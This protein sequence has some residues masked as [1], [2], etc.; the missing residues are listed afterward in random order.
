ML[1]SSS[2][3]RENYL[4]ARLRDERTRLGDITMHEKPNI[5]ILRTLLEMNR[6]HPAIHGNLA[7]LEAYLKLARDHHGDVKAVYK[8]KDLSIHAPDDYR[9]S[10]FVGRS[11][12]AG[13]AT[14]LPKAVVNTIWKDTHVEVDLVSSYPTMLISCFR[15]LELPTLE[16]YVNNPGPIINDFGKS[17]GISRGEMKKVVNTMICAYPKPPSDLGIGFSDEEK[18][19]A[20]TS[21]R[22]YHGMKNDLGVISEYMRKHYKTFLDMIKKKCESSSD[23]SKKDRLIGSALS[24]LCG[25][26]ENVVMRCIIGF[27]SEN[28]QTNTM[29]NDCIWKFDGIIVPRDMADPGMTGRIE[30]RVHEKTG[31]RVNVAIRELQGT[32]ALSIPPEELQVLGAYEAWKQN[33]EKTYFMMYDPAQYCRVKPDGLLQDLTKQGFDL[34]TQ[35]EDAEM[36]KLWR[37]DSAKRTYLGKE[38]APEPL[39]LP[40]GYYNLWRGLKATSLPIND[41]PVDLTLYM[42]HVALL[43]G[44]DDEDN[45]PAIDYMH[46][47]LAFKFQRP[48]DIWRI[49]VFI[50]SVQG[51][52]KDIWLDF[53]FD[54]IGQKYGIKLQKLEDIAG[55]DNSAIEAKLL[56]GFS[57]MD[58]KD[59]REN[60]EV[61]KNMITST[62]VTIKKKY[63]HPCVINNSACFIGFSNNYNAIQISADDR[64]IFSVTASGI[65][66]N[67]PEY[68]DPLIAYL[69]RDDVKR[70][71]YD[72]YMAMDI[73]D[74]NPSGDRP[75]TATMKEM[76][77]DSITIGDIFLK[78]RFPIWMLAAQGNNFDTKLVHDDQVV[79]VPLRIVYDEF[80]VLAADL[81][82]KDTD[83]KHKMERLAKRMLE[84]ASGRIETFFTKTGDMKTPIVKV[85]I[86][87]P[88]YYK[89]DI[90]SITQ[91]INEKLTANEEQD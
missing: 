85:R 43:M 77:M 78:T 63:A 13:T 1:S 37:R 11:Y 67:K 10:M 88:Q 61:L 64:R 6:D 35:A 31:I 70:A 28:D 51:V 60:I 90:A 29:L 26:A 65:H 86:M 83:S 89:F 68:H 15:D 79:R 30:R 58:A 54:I 4:W 22:F 66:A 33:F 27:L 45:Q 42:N 48:G 38:F 53:L 50:R 19:R 12:P 56:V 62:R 49:M 81:N 36:M 46:K 34:L 55:S 74:F 47:L 80:A 21:S 69:K 84:E 76:V 24:H 25:D 41:I 87:G 5:P 57:E 3:R 39:Y 8:Q 20:I 17:F 18:L 9:G 82:Y 44:G 75:T 71:V 2:R 91:Y 16:V 23:A 72:F 40:N 7:S 59:C 73:T 52:G 32:I 14:F